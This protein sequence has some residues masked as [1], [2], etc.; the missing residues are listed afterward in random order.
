M[1]L[2]PLHYHPPTTIEAAIALQDQLRSQVIRQ[3]DFGTVRWV[4]GIDVGFI[5]DQARAAIAVLNFPDLTLHESVV[6]LAPI[7]FP[8]IPGLLAF[9]E[10]PA[11]LQAFEQLNTQ[12]DLL[13][14]D[15]NGYLHPRRCGSACQI[16]LLTG[17]PAIGVAKT[18]HLGHHE[19]VGNQRGDWQ[20]I[21][22]RKEV[23]GAV[24]RSQPKVKP[25]YVSVGHR[26]GLDTA[27]QL[28]LQC[29]Q[30]YRLPETT[31]WADHLAN[32][33]TNVLV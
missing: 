18:Y 15:G 24:V 3:D 33:H 8:Y 19:S 22:D 31:R 6:T 28:T 23:I 32:G 12:P 7:G 14:C 4:A 20:P 27:I 11:I 5:G 10:L 26:I 13:L 16:G 2:Q 9:R 25:I 17:I 29:T 30:Q 1:P 21:W